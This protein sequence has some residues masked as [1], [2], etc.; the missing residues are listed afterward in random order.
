MKTMTHPSLGCD[1][2]LVSRSS[3]RFLLLRLAPFR[4]YSRQNKSRTAAALRLQ[5]SLVKPS[6]PEKFMPTLSLL[7]LAVTVQSNL[8]KALA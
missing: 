6:Q 2:A 8:G 1:S 5:S 7:F 3:G 4:T